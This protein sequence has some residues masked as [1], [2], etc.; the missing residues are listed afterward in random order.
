[1]NVSTLRFVSRAQFNCCELLQQLCREIVVFAY[2]DER[3]CVFTLLAALRDQMQTH[4][5]HK[6]GATLVIVLCDNQEEE[7]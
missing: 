6:V 4:T 7:D 3:V 2:W 1:M 5:R